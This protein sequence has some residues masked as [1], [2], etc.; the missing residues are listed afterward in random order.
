[1][2]EVVLVGPAVADDGEASAARPRIIHPAAG[3]RHFWHTATPPHRGKSAHRAA[4]VKSASTLI[5]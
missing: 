3:W 4:A 2:G 5:G 1:M